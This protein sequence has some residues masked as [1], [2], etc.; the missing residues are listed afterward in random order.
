M[1][2]FVNFMSWSLSSEY[3]NIHKISI[4][5]DR[6]VCLID[7]ITCNNGFFNLHVIIIH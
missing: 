4:Y 5:P 1:T 2:L 7:H 6:L 3:Q